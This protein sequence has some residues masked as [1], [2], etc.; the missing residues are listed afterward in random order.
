[1]PCSFESVQFVLRLAHFAEVAGATDAEMAE[2]TKDSKADAPEPTDEEKL[3]LLGD[4]GKRAVEVLRYSWGGSTNVEAAFDLLLTRAKECKLSPEFVKRTN[5]IIFS[6]ME[7]DQ[8]AG[9]YGGYYAGRSNTGAAQTKWD[10]THEPAGHDRSAGSTKVLC[11]HATSLSSTGCQPE[12]CVG[13]EA[14]NP[15]TKGR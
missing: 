1:M 4:V 3:E 7:F 6:D 5:L 2:E 14:Q 10:T 11:S 9:M 8:G 13:D 12:R 15:R